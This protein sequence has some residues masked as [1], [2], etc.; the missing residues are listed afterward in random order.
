MKRILVPC[1]FESPA[2]EAFKFAVNLAALTE[3]ELFVLN[4]LDLPVVSESALG[5][6]QYAF[7]PELL[8]DLKAEANKNFAKLKESHV[9]TMP[10]TFACIQGPVRPT[11]REY[12]TAQNIDQV[13]MG[14]HGSRGWEEFFIGSNTEKIVRTTSVP[15]FAIRKAVDVAHIK[16][17]VF[18]TTLELHQH[19]LVDK[20][21][22]LQKV[23]HAK[24]HVLIVDTPSR[25]GRAREEMDAFEEFVKH[26]KL[27]DYTENVRND[28]YEQD[29]ILNFAKEINADMIAMGT[30]SRRGLAHLFSGSIAEEV[31]HHSNYLL[32]TCTMKHKKK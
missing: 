31:L 25:Q 21:K 17:I 22:E 24:L 16:N 10:V 28:A 7:S 2:L 11:I 8:K 18:P 9:P 4:V 14:T 26:Y 19:E 13:I 30:H 23:F 27:T 29:G 6:P 1:D 5:I 12:I 3:G 15:V 32:W 20:V